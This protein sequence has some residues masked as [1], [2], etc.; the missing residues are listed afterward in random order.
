[1]YVGGKPLSSRGPRSTKSH[2]QYR[3]VGR[4]RIPGFLALGAETHR[5]AA[6]ADSCANRAVPAGSPEA[7]REAACG[8][9]DA[10]PAAA[11]GAGPAAAAGAAHS[12]PP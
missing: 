12:D 7:R 6:P 10:A 1:M 3:F 11:A 9:D 2:H 4:D 5:L 8:D